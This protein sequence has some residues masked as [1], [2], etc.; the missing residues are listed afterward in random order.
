MSKILSPS[1]AKHLL[2]LC[3]IGRLFDV[4]HWI[5][6]G[7]SLS[8]P[9]DLKTTPLEVALDTGFH[10]LVEM[11]VRHEASQNLKNRALRHAVSLK[12]LDFI[13]LL[14][15]NGAE[16]SS[17][18]FI[19][20]LR[21]WEPTIIRYFLDHGADFITDSP[22]A[23]A[24]SERIRTALR[25][26]RECRDKYPN[27]APHL[28][29]QADRA[30]RHFCFQDDLKW[31]S[32]LMWVG[33]DPRSS[34]P[35]LD[36]D[37]DSD[38]PEERTTAIEAAAH[39]ENVQIMKRLKP[40]VERDNV[41][42]LLIYA[43][44]F[45]H[46]DVVRYLLEIGAKPN[47]EPNV[48]STALHQC[49]LSFQYKSLRYRISSTWYGT[50]CKAPRYE[51]SKT[52]ET[53]QLLLEKGARWQPDNAREL[54]SVRRNLYECEP[55]VTLELV[56]LLVNHKACSKDALDNLLRTPAMK[57]HLIP[58][59]IKLRQM[60][61]DVRTTEQKEEDERQKEAFR[62]WALRGLASTYNREKIYEEIWL[63]PIQH[64]AKRYKLSDVGFA[65]VCRKLDIPRP[66]RGYWAMKAA[67]KP[68]PKRPPLSKLAV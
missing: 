50:S 48:G 33:A 36:D 46:A 41:D 13:E 58:V 29:E 64:V 6:S 45:G 44:S 56:E 61:F 2:R 51:V 21:V 7:E 52:L 37:E 28:Q 42:K 57:K 35:T 34:G 40:D 63:E 24:F 65:K 23:V 22:F 47:E 25:P 31:V 1:E 66:G 53:I 60:G 5:A 54:A 9:A 26:W 49:L 19:S 11:L 62:R 10:S 55:D 20:V 8:V 14:V 38:D 68:V 17:V 16:I 15:S 4:Q 3:K 67:G 32:L 43:A 18:P 30:L 27:A 59:R 39:S 12:R